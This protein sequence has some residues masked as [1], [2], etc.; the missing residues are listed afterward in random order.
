[1]TEKTLGVI[2]DIAIK[3]KE[4]KKVIFTDNKIKEERKEYLKE[5]FLKLGV[6]LVL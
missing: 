6:E 1:M 3:N 4:V 5:M 2:R